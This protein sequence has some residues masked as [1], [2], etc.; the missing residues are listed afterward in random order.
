M[1][2]P[3]GP[4]FPIHQPSRTLKKASRNV[5]A[6][7]EWYPMLGLAAAPEM[8]IAVPNVMALRSCPLTP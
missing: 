3:A 6:G 2:R 8:A 7:A 5:T 4:G 1:L